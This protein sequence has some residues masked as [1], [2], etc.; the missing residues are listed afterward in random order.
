MIKSARI[1]VN[2]VIMSI[3]L[4]LTCSLFTF[5]LLSGC[6]SSISVEKIEKNDDKK[7]VLLSD[8]QQKM[9]QQMRNEMIAT[10]QLSESCRLVGKGNEKEALT[11]LQNIDWSNTGLK[12]SKNGVNNAGVVEYFRKRLKSEGDECD[13]FTTELIREAY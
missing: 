1:F 5:F 6:A 9:L 8:E 7:E 11:K 4:K 2:E 3:G 12:I 10:D 13:V